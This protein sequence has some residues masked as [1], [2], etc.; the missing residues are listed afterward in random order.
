MRRHKLDRFD[1]PK[2]GKRVNWPHEG[3]LRNNVPEHVVCPGT[4]SVRRSTRERHARQWTD[5]D[6]SAG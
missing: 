4:P 3:E 5:P 2:C 1:C 6:R